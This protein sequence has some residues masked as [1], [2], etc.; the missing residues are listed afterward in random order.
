MPGLRGTLL[1]RNGNALA[2]SEDAATIY[3]TPYQVKNPPQTAAKLA[4]IL[5]VRPRAKCSSALTEE[6]G[7]SYVAHKVDLRHRGAKI[8][9]LQLEGIG[10]LPDSR[11]TY[12]QGDMA[13]QVI[14]A[15]GSE[16]EGLTGLE[17]GEES[18][19]RGSERRT[20]GRQRRARRPDP[21][22]NRERS[23]ATAKTSS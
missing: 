10:Q 5:G 19:L 3:A 15:V 12:P 6:S 4:P 18:V 21:A 17:D 11:R 14:G 22:G 16:D 20:A 23:Q 7:F 9:R 2:A 13:G 1:D 8:E